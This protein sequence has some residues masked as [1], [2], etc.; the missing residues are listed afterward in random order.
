MCYPKNYALLWAYL[1]NLSLLSFLTFGAAAHLSAQRKK[2]KPPYNYLTHTKTVAEIEAFTNKTEKV[3]YMLC[4]EFSNKAQADT[5][6]IPYL[7]APQQIIAV[8]I[9]QDTRKGEYWLYMGWFAFGEPKKALSQGI[10]KLSSEKDQ[11]DNIKYKL[12][13][14]ALPEEDAEYNSFSEEWKKEQPFAGLRPRDLLQDNSC[15][16]YIIASETQ[17]NEFLFESIVDGLCPQPISEQ[18]RYYTFAGR[19]TPSEI[20]HYTAFYDAQKKIVFAY[21]RP[22]GFKLIRQD[23]KQPAYAQPIK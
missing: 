3:F 13:F 5:T 7:K 11:Y 19:L 14:Y 15:V 2:N 17:P 6:K 4:G 20:N 22:H 10:F 16:S 18:L 21:P 23:K 12:A 1:L 9:W 8:P